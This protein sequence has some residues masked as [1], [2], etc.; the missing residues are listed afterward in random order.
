MEEL[1]LK[2]VGQN[3]NSRGTTFIKFANKKPGRFEFLLTTWF[4]MSG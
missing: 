3:Y 2:I 1:A 4:S